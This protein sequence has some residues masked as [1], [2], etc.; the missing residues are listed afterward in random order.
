MQPLVTVLMPVYNAE[1][2]LQEAIESILRQTLANFEFL[3]VDD[4]S[5]DNSVAIIKS[6][7][8]ARIR[9]VQNERNLGI[10]A[11]LN[12][13]IELASCE[14]IA[15]MDAD[16]ISYPARLQK[17]YDFF[18]AN[19]DCALLSAWAQE[20][21]ETGEPIRT[22]KWRRPFFYYNLTF[23]CWIY[24]PTVMYRRSAV[25]DAGAYSTPYSE[26]YDLWW[27][28][29]RRYKIDTLPDVLLDY[30][31]TGQSLY[32]AT[33]KAE[34]EEAQ[35][36]QILRNLTFYTGAGFSITYNE[37][38]CYRHNFGP[39]LQENS[40]SALIRAIQKLDYINK[41]ILKKEN[42][43]RDPVAIR[44]AAHEKKKFIIGQLTFHLPNAKKFLFLVRLGQWRK[45][46]GVL[47]RAARPRH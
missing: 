25:L 30:R 43:N 24:H 39:L 14:L 23:E 15:R 8:D 42:V 35:Y 10:S 41:R 18:T 9:F 11:T 27:H 29:A 28:L 47:H 6:Y 1:A 19:P 38:E 32:R 46:Y 33:K 22:E 45:L 4:G 16:D 2:Y 5:T 21:T 44:Q 40:M 20:V 17:Q 7:N 12:R 13:G 34:Y 3:I 37:V 26:D 36:K 31:L